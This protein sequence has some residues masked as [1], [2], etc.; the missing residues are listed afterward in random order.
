LPASQRRCC[1][2]SSSTAIPGC[3]LF[4]KDTTGTTAFLTAPLKSQL[5]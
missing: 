2:A 3:A 5:F 1:R 4:A